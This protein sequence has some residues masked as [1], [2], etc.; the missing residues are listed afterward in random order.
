MGRSRDEELRLSVWEGRRAARR[1]WEKD[2]ILR[3]KEMPIS[4]LAKV[5]GFFRHICAV[6][7]WYVCPNV[8]FGTDLIQVTNDLQ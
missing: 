2:E 4:L 7:I 3:R 1:R 8:T 6:A 5:R